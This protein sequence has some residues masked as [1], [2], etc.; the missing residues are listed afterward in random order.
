MNGITFSKSSTILRKKRAIIN[1][2][3]RDERC[4]AYAIL[5][6]L[7]PSQM[8]SH[9]AKQYLTYYENEGLHRMEYP[10][11][12]DQMPEIEEILNLKINIFSFFDDAG[13]GGYPLYISR[14]ENF[15]ARSIY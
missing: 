15:R 5:S 9:R 3:N 6:A 7:H 11:G 10:V 4:F 2:K 1:V 8:H 12:P 14:K 13:K